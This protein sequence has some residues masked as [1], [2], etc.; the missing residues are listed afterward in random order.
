MDDPYHFKDP[1]QG[2]SMFL[3]R[4]EELR[5]IASFIKGN[6]SVSIMGPRGIGKTSLLLHLMR[7]E[8]AADLGFEGTLLAYLDCE[9]FPARRRRS[10]LASAWEWLLHSL[11]RVSSQSQP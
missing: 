6:Q 11:I 9:K 3:G 1:G 4:E 5:E 7:A 2:S 10:S 8:T